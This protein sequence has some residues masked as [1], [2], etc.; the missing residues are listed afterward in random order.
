NI[1]HL[2]NPRLDQLLEEGR[3]TTDKEKRRQIYADFQRFLLEESPAIFI[4]YPT[5]HYVFRHGFEN[6]TLP[7]YN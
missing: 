7:G 3:I 2:N 5:Y 1:T 4:E 6:A